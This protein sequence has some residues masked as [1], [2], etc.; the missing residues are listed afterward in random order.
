MNDLARKHGQDI[1]QYTE[2][3]LTVLL[4]D[5]SKL[6][7]L[8]CYEAY[9]GDSNAAEIKTTICLMRDSLW[10]LTHEIEKLKPFF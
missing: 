3:I 10:D 1:I 5:A 9:K 6:D 8:F 4:K 7:K 2:V